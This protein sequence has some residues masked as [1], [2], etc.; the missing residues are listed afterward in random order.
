MHTTKGRSFLSS[1]CSRPAAPP[2]L[3]RAKA[4]PFLVNNSSFHVLF[5]VG[6]LFFQFPAISANMKL[7]WKSQVELTTRQ[8]C[9]RPIHMSYADA[10]VS[11]SLSLL[12]S[13]KLSA[14]AQLCQL[15][16]SF[17]FLP[18]Q[19]LMQNGSIE[20]ALCIEIVCGMTFLLILCLISLVILVASSLTQ[21][22]S[23]VPSH[24][25]LWM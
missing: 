17:F 23:S 5:Q 20:R 3:A 9:T 1:D 2:P 19:N 7:D 14:A 22:L 25:Q 15:S 11:L 8:R 12:F 21:I 16:T 10:H 13:G 18:I 6:L 24:C 4:I